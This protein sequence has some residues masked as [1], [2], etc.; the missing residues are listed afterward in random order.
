MKFSVLLSVYKNEKPES[1]N[2][3]FLSIWDQQSLKP[4]QIVLVKDGPLT[5]KLDSMID[6]W[7]KKLGDFLT[8]VV[9][10]KNVGL[11]KALNQGL[12]ACQYELIA[13]MDTDDISLPE[14]FKKQ[15]LFMKNHPNLAASSAFFEE[16]DSSF[17]IS[18]GKRFLALKHEDIYHYGKKR[19]PLNHITTIFRKSAIDSVGGY[20]PLR[21]AQDYGLWSLLMVKGYKLANIPETL[22]HVRAGD[23]L[24]ERRGPNFLIHEIKLL[25]FQRNIGYLNY[26]EYIRNLLIR[27]TLR[28]SPKFIKKII[29]NNSRN[30]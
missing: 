25:Q 16:F 4:N 9:L 29:Y 27:S 2:Q 19:S 21:K 17:S 15:V 14:R 3:A 12:K 1:L 26:F 24:I 13:R 7:H 20:P 10:K 5:F 18:K 6:F 23:E 8:I 30:L 28:L 22:A 11:G